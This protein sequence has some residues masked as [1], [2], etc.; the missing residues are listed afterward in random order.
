MDEDIP[1]LSDEAE[2]HTVKIEN[3][4]DEVIRTILFARSLPFLRPIF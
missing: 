4:G 1:E 3:G 2:D